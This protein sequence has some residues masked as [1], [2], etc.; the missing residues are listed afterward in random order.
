MVAIGMYVIL[1]SSFMRRRERMATPPL[2][3]EATLQ[4]NGHVENVFNIV[5]RR[6]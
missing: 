2:Q 5:R 4:S 6:Q 1:L 3:S